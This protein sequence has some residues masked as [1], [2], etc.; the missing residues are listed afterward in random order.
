M[1][2]LDIIK[3][4][5]GLRLKPYK[6]SADISTIGYGNTFYE[7]GKKVTMKD[8]EIT[9]E[10]AEELLN[11]YV[12]TYIINAIEELVTIELNDNQKSA[13]ASFIY[14]LGTPNFKSSTLLKTLNKSSFDAMK[15]QWMLWCKAKVKGVSTVIPGLRTRRQ[16][17]LDLFFT[18]IIKEE[19]E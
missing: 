13:L 10:R 19:S 12:D 15:A 3:E 5:E 6:C 9:I 8:K 11:W 2:N 16:R 14:N 1:I 7:N 4:S 17:E 18:P